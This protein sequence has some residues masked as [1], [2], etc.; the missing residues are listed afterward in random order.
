VNASVVTVIHNSADVLADMIGA[1]PA[2]LELVVVDNASKDGGANIARGLRG[3]VKVVEMGGN[4]GFGAGCNAGARNARGEVLVFLNPDCR[5]AP[6][7]LE[8]LVAHALADPQSIFGPAMLHADGTLRHNLRRRSE[9]IHEVLERLPSAARWIPVRLRR[10]LPP[11]DPRY[12]EG[13]NVDYLQG[14]CLALTRA[15]F[16]AAGGF[17]ED[18]FLYSEEESLCDAVCANGGRCIYLPEAR[19]D[20]AG[21]TTTEKVPTF[22][23]R[24][25]F[26]SRAVFYRKRYGE[27][28]GQLSIASIAASVCLSWLLTPLALLLR[29]RASKLPRIQPHALRGLGSGAVYR[30]GRL[31]T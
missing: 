19:V 25:A 10:D 24:H 23:I 5:P 12:R 4:R 8:L 1:V 2:Q 3:D 6:G 22:A 16:V 29:T 30:F 17:D 18:F 15:C 28:K 31:R 13:G 7:S 9:P 27:V 11:D 26:R 20:H 21:S 14:A